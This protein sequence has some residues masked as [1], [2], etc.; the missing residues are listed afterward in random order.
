[1]TLP[2]SDEKASTWL[3]HAVFDALCGSWR[4]ERSIPGQATMN[5]HARF[6]GQGDGQLLYRE[7]GLLRLDNGRTCQAYRS[8]VYRRLPDGFS[9]WF[10]E[11]EPRLFHEVRL[12]WDGEALGGQAT[13]PCGADRYDTSYAFRPD[14]S[15]VVRHAV[16]GP[17]K[18]YVSTTV[19]HR[20]AQDAD[21]AAAA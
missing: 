14:G 16:V 15:F 13:H 10:D 5:G 12:A 21:A 6:D 1:M 2:L 7:S 8:Y 17:R 19:F 3:A 20:D 18:G 11:P 4:F 9:V